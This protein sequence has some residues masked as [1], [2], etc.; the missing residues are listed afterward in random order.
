MPIKDKVKH[1]EYMR[2]YRGKHL[3]ISKYI[4]QQIALGV[5]SFDIGIGKNQTVNDKS[6]TRVR[7][8]VVKDKETKTE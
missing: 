8:Q 2:T 3:K 6:P 4:S 5:T 1:A 7:F